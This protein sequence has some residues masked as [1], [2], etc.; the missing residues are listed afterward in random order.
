[1]RPCSA[2]VLIL[3]QLWG[4][5]GKPYLTLETP[6]DGRPEVKYWHLGLVSSL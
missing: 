4:V 1:M 5:R 3:G 6:K 2:G